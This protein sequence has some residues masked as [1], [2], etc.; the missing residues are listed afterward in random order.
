MKRLS[1]FILCSLFLASAANGPASGRLQWGQADG[2]T[3]INT[4]R[5]QYGFDISTKTTGQPSR[6]DLTSEYK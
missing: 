6:F 3:Q 1:S 2:R 5:N 4:K